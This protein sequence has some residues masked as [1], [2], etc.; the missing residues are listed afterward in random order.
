MIKSL[1]VAIS[2]TGVIG[3]EGGIPWTVPEDMKYF[4]S[5]TRRKTVIM[6]RHTWF[7]LPSK[8]RPL[9]N[10]TNIV[11]SAKLVRDKEDIPDGVILVESLRTAWD[12]SEKTGAAEA[13]VI[14]GARLYAEALPV[15]DKLYITRI[16]LTCEGD[17][18][19]NPSQD[20][21]DTLFDKRVVLEGESSNGVEYVMEEYT[22]KPI[23]QKR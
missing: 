11:V 16:R 6:G 18:E 22:R 5:V 8:S 12:I 4:G 15:V 7:S 10:R 14:G 20:Y 1:I 9:P 23:F 2:D 19:F 13:V 21:L 17:T 3:N